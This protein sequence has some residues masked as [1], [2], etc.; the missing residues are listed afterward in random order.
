MLDLDPKEK[1]LPIYSGL[2]R[3]KQGLQ[4]LFSEAIR[5][6]FTLRNY[7]KDSKPFQILGSQQHQPLLF[8]QATGGKEK[9]LIFIKN[10]HI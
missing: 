2:A 9:F 7:N 1:K 3:A 10:I 6:S 8:F 5:T 4:S